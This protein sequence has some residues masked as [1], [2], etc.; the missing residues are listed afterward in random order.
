MYILC[1]MLF[2]YSLYRTHFCWIDTAS[3]ATKTLLFPLSV[4]ILCC[5]ERVHSSAKVF[6]KMD[7]WHSFGIRR[8]FR[9]IAGILVMPSSSA[10]LISDWT[11]CRTTS[12]AISAWKRSVL[13]PICPANFRYKFFPNVLRFSK[14]SVCIFLKTLSPPCNLAASAAYAA[15]HALG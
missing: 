10:S 13:R 7:T 1:S 11:I 9:N 4:S 3:D 14:S 5:A 12:P 6:Q 15:W 8:P 2:M